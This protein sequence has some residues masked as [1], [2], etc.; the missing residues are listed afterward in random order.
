MTHHT[1]ALSFPHQIAFTEDAFAPHNHT[2][3][4]LLAPS[5]SPSRALAFVDLSV[6]EA[7]PSLCARIV[8]YAE[9]HRDR[10]LMTTKPVAIMGG[11]ACKNDFSRLEG[12][13][14]K[15]HAA[16]MDRHSYILIIGGG[17]VL[18]LV[19][20]AAS[21]A[22]R[23]IRQIR[24]PT[25]TL[26]QADGGVGVKNGVNYFG[27]KNWLG[28][29]SVPH[30]VVNDLHFLASLPETERR[31]GIIEA[32][33]VALIRDRAFFEKIEKFSTCLAHPQ[34]EALHWIV[35]RSAEL[36]LE[37][38]AT[39]GDPFESGSARPLDFGH[40]IAHKLEQLSNF[41]IG[42][43]DAVAIG[44]AVDLQYSADAGILAQDECERIL[45]LIR[46]LGFPTFAPQ[47]M[48]AGTNG[49]PA[50]LEGLEEFREHL[51]GRLTIT[52]IPAIG[53]KIEVHTMDE[54]TI[55][56]ALETLHAQAQGQAVAE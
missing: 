48:Q 10:L 12:V 7:H 41:D 2:L 47:L 46:K 39:S 34:S 13:W 38:I 28:T 56:A 20:F 31:A 29:F 26:S 40:W 19:G 4:D 37:H 25:T 32:I 15:I 49:K 21:T 30:A 3:V 14:K 16:G 8:A 42:H 51:G 11:E 36:H 52:L 1:I 9:A 55:R 53:R 50:I 35:R 17:A 33:K 43:G 45:E 23:G 5:E 54:R 24:F 27:K 22:H 44:I 6:A 18:D